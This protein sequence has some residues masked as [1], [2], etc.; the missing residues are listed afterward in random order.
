MI[1]VIDNYDSFTFNLVQYMLM[2]EVEVSVHR[3]DQVSVDEVLAAKPSGIVLSPGPCTPFQAGISLDLVRQAAGRVPIL[4]VCLGHQTIGQAFGGTVVRADEVMHGKVSMIGQD[5][6]SAIFAG[7]PKQFLVT[8]Y[9]SLIV[10]EPL[11]DCLKVTARTEGG[12]VMALEHI[13]YPIYGVQF[14]PEA[15]LTEYGHEMVRNF[16]RVAGDLQDQST[17]Q[18][19][20]AVRRSIIDLE[21][22]VGEAQNA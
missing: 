9:H 20:P 5:G 6:G 19:E 4:G 17:V 12:M 14:H 3:N 7:L 1:V 22:H 11:P 10:R 8:R 18:R 2:A 16:L 13:E 15:V 21:S